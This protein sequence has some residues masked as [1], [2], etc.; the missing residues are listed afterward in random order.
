ML[1]LK[2]LRWPLNRSA[3]LQDVRGWLKKLPVTRGLKSVQSKA[4]KCSTICDAM[5]RGDVTETGNGAVP[6]ME[7]EKT[8]MKKSLGLGS[9]IAMIVGTMIGRCFTS[10]QDLAVFKQ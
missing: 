4:L 6:G 10:R 7:M 2:I 3:F 9:G 8:E 1:P 5:A